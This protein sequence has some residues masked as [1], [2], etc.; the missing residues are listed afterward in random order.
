MDFRTEF[1][2]FA[3]SRLTKGS[4]YNF[5]IALKEKKNTRFDIN[6]SNDK[7]C[8]IIHIGKKTRKIKIDRPQDLSFPKYIEKV[9]KYMKYN[10]GEFLFL[11]LPKTNDIVDS[12]KCIGDVNDK[13]LVKIQEEDIIEGIT[14]SIQN[15]TFRTRIKDEEVSYLK[16]DDEESF[17]AIFDDFDD[18]EE[19]VIEFDETD[20]E[21]EEVE[22][23]FDG[24]FSEEETDKVKFESLFENN[25][26]ENI[27]ELA[28]EAYKKFTKSTIIIGYTPEDKWL[29]KQLEN[30]G[31][32]WFS[33]YYIW[34]IPKSKTSKLNKLSDERN[35]YIVNSSGIKAL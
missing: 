34:R 11:C 13:I 4:K 29:R 33:K 6:L 15:G 24:V 16:S 10:R 35:L 5:V 2:S 8:L 12:W 31:A 23:E 30:A 22:E 20:T 9:K 18:T 7:T 25:S 19:E 21:E 26:P 14:K 28:I 1:L 27:M 17:N 3:L 32:K